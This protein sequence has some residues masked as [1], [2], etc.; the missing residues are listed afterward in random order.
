[1]GFGPYNSIYMG[2]VGARYDGYMYWKG[3][4]GRFY[5]AFTDILTLDKPWAL[6]ELQ[7]DYPTLELVYW[8]LELSTLMNIC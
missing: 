3:N 2:N 7:P 4:V 5:S 6:S 1:M 8:E